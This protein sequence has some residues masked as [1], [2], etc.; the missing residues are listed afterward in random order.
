MNNTTIRLYNNVLFT[1]SN[2]SYDGAVLRITSGPGAGYAY[3]IGTYDNVSRNITLTTPFI[4]TPTT[5]SQAAIEFN[6]GNADAFVKQVPYTSGATSN[7]SASITVLNKSGSRS[8]GAAFISESSL[9]SLL[10][11]LPDT[12]IGYGANGI[13]NTTYSYRKKFTTSFNSGV[14]TPIQVELNENFL[15][16]TSTSNISSTIMNNF[17][18][19]CTNK[20]TSARANGDIIKAT[21]TITSGTPEQA[22]FDTGSS[23]PNDNFS[24]TIFAK[25]DFDNGVVPKQKTLR[26]INDQSFSGDTPITLL[27]SPTG[28]SANVYLPTG[29]VVITNPSRKVGVKESLYIS[30]VS[31]VK[32]YD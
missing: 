29:Q 2:N 20:G 31:A 18:I 30:D 15:G 4:E 12:F 10:F 19:V 1:T 28:S 23:D 9:S 22:V 32:I 13:T 6:F 7:A 14:S 26:L 17:L 3:T 8:N 25:V 21:V 24:A 27:N 16:A 5:S 11:P